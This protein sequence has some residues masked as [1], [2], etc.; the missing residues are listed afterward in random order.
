[1]K[2]IF[3]YLLFYCILIV[4]GIYINDLFSLKPL[5]SNNL[6]VLIVS[7]FVASR[8]SGV[9]RGGS[10]EKYILSVISGLSYSLTSYLIVELSPLTSITALEFAGAFFVASF[11]IILLFRFK[12]I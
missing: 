1:M 6:L 3:S 10:K 9:E 12:V 4:A 8:I 5:Y 2:L 11:S 7:A